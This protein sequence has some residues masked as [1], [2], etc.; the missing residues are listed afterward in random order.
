M[1]IPIVVGVGI[2]LPRCIYAC[3]NE[4]EVELVARMLQDQGYMPASTEMEVPDTFK[5]FYLELPKRH[6]P[7]LN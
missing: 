2:A 3:R 4:K 5:E 6:E 1:I 7:S